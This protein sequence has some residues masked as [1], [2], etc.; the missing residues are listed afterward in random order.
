MRSYLD[1]VGKSNELKLLLNHPAYKGNILL[2]LEGETDIRLFRSLFKCNGI[3]LDSVDGKLDLINVVS[4]LISDGYSEIV[5]ICDADFDHILGLVDTREVKGVYVTDCHD[6]EM[7]MINSS[8]M[9]KFI[10]EYSNHSNYSILAEEAKDSAL[11]AASVL[12]LLRLANTKRHFNLNFKGLNFKSFVN[13]DKQLASVDLNQLVQI[14]IKRSPSLLDGVTE[15]ILHM[16]YSNLAEERHHM[17]QLCC[18]H[19]VTNILAMIYSQRWAACINNVNVDKVE[20]A[21]RLGYSLND[22]KATDLYKKISAAIKLKGIDTE[23]CNN[24]P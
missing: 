14:L 10:D 20:Q 16:E 18:G 21:L 22:F 2:L 17:A 9:Q 7:M 8:S 1:V 3:K 24:I 4:L 15:D 19:D 5:G 13:I 6:A 23:V 12:G 11:D